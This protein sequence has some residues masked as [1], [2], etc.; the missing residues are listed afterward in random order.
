MVIVDEN[1]LSVFGVDL[2]RSVF[3]MVCFVRSDLNIVR[4]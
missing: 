4:V 3:G 2:L 1:D